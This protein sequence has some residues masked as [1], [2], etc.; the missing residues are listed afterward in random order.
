[1]LPRGDEPEP[2]PEPA[3]TREEEE[4]QHLYWEEMRPIR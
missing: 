3:R 2:E 4:A 1:V